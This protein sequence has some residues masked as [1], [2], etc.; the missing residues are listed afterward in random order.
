MSRA[1][2]ESQ[3]YLPEELPDEDDAFEY[4][5]H[6]KRIENFPD[7]FIT[8]TGMVISFVKPYKPRIMSTYTNQHGHHYVDLINGTGRHKLLVHRLMAKAFLPNSNNYPIVRH[9]DDDP[10]NNYV[11]NLAWGTYAENTQD[12]IR[13]GNFY[14]EPVYCIEDN[15]EFKSVHEAAKYYDVSPASIVHV[16]KGKIKSCLKKHFCYLREKDTID[17]SKLTIHTG[18]K[19]IIAI[20]PDGNE[21][22]YQSRKEAAED[23]GIPE[24]GISSVVNG[25]L[26]HTHGWRFREV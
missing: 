4:G 21:Y 26:K 13:N 7:Y 2:E 20:D 10:D 1:F 25:H 12:A 14:M 9:I 6:Y 3:L 22:I 23:I 15:M 24:C 17:R 5:V 11:G 8:N 18:F 16:C 19:P